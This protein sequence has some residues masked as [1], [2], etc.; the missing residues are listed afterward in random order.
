MIERPLNEFPFRFEQMFSEKFRTPQGAHSQW[1]TAA[2][3]QTV[4]YGTDS[5]FTVFQAL[6][7]RLLS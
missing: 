5:L 1:P 4:P 3:N 7:A 2:P 6:R